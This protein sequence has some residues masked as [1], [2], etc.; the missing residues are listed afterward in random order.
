MQSLFARNLE[1]HSTAFLLIAGLKESKQHNA[2]P[3]RRNRSGHSGPGKLPIKLVLWENSGMKTTLELPDQLMKRIKMRAVE[4]NQ[5]LK[6]AVAQLL[7]LGLSSASKEKVSV[8]SPR[9]VR[10]KKRGRLK[11]EDI[12]SAI[13]GGR[14]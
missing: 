13:A 4:R 10:L 1:W 8:R 2:N 5:K 11:F 12:E 9:P 6:D 14:D 7:E 3:T